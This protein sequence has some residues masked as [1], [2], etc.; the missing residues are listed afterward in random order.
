LK[1]LKTKFRDLE[2]SESQVQEKMGLYS[3]YM[4]EFIYHTD[5][6]IQI[7]ICKKVAVEPCSK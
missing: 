2:Q 3:E 6:T 1:H 7:Q 4:K 5:A